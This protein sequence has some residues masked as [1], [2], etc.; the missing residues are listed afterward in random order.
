[1]A[2]LAV[3]ATVIFFLFALCHA[4]IPLDLPENEGESFHLPG[5]VP[6][7]MIL[8]PSEKPESEP[9]T[10]VELE[11]E[12]TSTDETQPKLEEADVTVTE[13]KVPTESDDSFSIPLKTIS[14]RPFNHR[15]GGRPIPLY[16]RHGHRCRFH[17][18]HH[19]RHHQHHDHDNDKSEDQIREF[20]QWGSKPIVVQSAIDR[21]VPYGNDMIL[22]S[23]NEDSSSDRGMVRQAPAKWKRFGHGGPRFHIDDDVDTKMKMKMKRHHRHVEGQVW[24]R[25]EHEE[26]EHK[27]RHEHEHGHG[28]EHKHEGGFMRKIRKFLNHHF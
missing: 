28:H 18:F 10:V 19:L 16:F 1:M 7:T 14:F 24:D 5:S 6:N 12:T 20:K 2:K 22:S 3:T 26:R 9:A 8:L 13:L 23:A 4:F 17:R 15:F 11:P 27:H 21:E 25:E